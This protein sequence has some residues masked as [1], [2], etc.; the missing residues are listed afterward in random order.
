MAARIAALVAAVAMVVGSLAVRD[1]MIHPNNGTNSTG[2]GSGALSIVCATEL[3]PVCDNLAAGGGVTVTTEAAA[4]TETRLKNADP[5]ALGPDG[6]LAPG[7]W[8]QM[9]DIERRG[10]NRPVLFRPT[11]DRVA[12]SPLVLVAWKDQADKL[13]AGPECQGTVTSKCIGDAVIAGTFKIGAPDATVDSI[14]LLAD[15]AF[16]GGLLANPDWATNDLN[17]DPA[18]APWITQLARSIDGARRDGAGSLKD[19]LTKRGV[20][21]GFVT[22][23]ADAGPTVV[24]AATRSQL[25]LVY[26]N[27]PATGDVMLGTT[28][29]SRGDRVR[30]LFQTDRA[31]GALKANGWR[32]AGQTG[33]PGIDPGTQLA[34][35]DGLPSAGVLEALEG[36]V[37]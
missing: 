31:K 30:K 12:R 37:K 21:N 25:Q 18:V 19:L 11:L 20:A 36:I 5:S 3:G 23:E 16:V 6:W 13:K 26:L 15:A 24:T 8:P 2:G 35:D 7:P 17:D 32:V 9:V 10:N 14:G 27:P 1:R 34:N 33:V 4:I 22:T 29:G 28:P